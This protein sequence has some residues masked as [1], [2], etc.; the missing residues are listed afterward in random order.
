MYVRN[1]RPA[2]FLIDWMY[3]SLPLVGWLTR[4]AEPIY[5]YNKPARIPFLNRYRKEGR[6][7][8]QECVSR[9]NKGASIAIFPEGTRNP[10]PHELRRARKGIGGI[11]L[12]TDVPVFPIGIDFPMRMQGSRIPKLGAVILRIGEPMHFTEEVTLHRIN[13]G[14]RL[15]PGQRKRVQ[16][17]LQ[18]KITYAIMVQ[19]AAL[20]GK[21]YP[22]HPPV[23]PEDIRLLSAAKGGYN[24]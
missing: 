7:A 14:S 18:A 3:G 22:F 21:A 23:P 4:V 16:S 5:V 1:G 24:V 10:N 19:L 12:E 13:G 8:Y 15:Q 9:L 2:G 6:N 11:V 20:S 17:F